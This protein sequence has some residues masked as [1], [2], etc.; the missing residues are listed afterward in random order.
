MFIVT[1][2]TMAFCTITCHGNTDWCF[3]KHLTADTNKTCLGC[4]SF[5]DAE[6]W[7]VIDS[8][9]K[10]YVLGTWFAAGQAQSS[11]RPETLPSELAWFFV[12]GYVWVGGFDQ[13]LEP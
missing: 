7:N 3:K 9:A 5:K 1:E 12:L 4:R 6:P 13:K 11:H 8:P 2:T 10:A